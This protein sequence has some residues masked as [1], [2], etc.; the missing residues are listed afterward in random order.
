MCRMKVHSRP[1][2]IS[3]VFFLVMLLFSFHVHSDVFV[4][5]DD[6]ET[7]Y[8]VGPY[9]SY[10]E[11]KKGQ[12]TIG[13]ALERYLKSD[14]SLTENYTEVF[15]Q[16]INNSVF[17]LF[18]SVEPDFSQNDENDWV[19]ELAQPLI[20]NAAL[21]SFSRNN[22]FNTLMEYDLS[23][24]HNS[25]NLIFDINDLVPGKTHFVLRVQ[26]YSLSQ[27]PLTL[28]KSSVLAK[29]HGVS[30]YWLGMYF[31]IMIIMM[32]VNIV[33]SLSIR[34]ILYFY[35][36][37]YI[38]SLIL[39]FLAYSGVGNQFI[40]GYFSEFNNILPF[41]SMILIM[42]STLLF[43]FN[44][45]KFQHFPTLLKSLVNY[46]LLLSLICLIVIF[47]NPFTRLLFIIILF[48][49]Y[50]LIIH[51]MVLFFNYKNLIEM[52]I[53]LISYFVLFV[54]TFLFILPIITLIPVNSSSNI[55]IYFGTLIQVFLLSFVL[56]NQINVER[57]MRYQ[58]LI[59]EN[60]AV[61]NMH[62]IEM[63]GFKRATMDPFTGL[64][65]RA[66]IE[67]FSK[68]FLT[69]KQ[70]N[71]NALAVAL[72]YVSD[73]HQVNRTLGFKS[74]D[75]LIEK[76]ASR[77]NLYAKDLPGCIPLRFSDEQVFF[78]AKLDSASFVVLFQMDDEKQTYVENIVH[79]LAL[80]NRPIDMLDMTLDV[81]AKA[82]MAFSP[83]HSTNIFTLIR[84]AQ[85]A[86]ESNNTSHSS[87]SEYSRIIGQQATR[88]LKLINDLRGAIKADE[89]TFF[90]QPQLDIVSQKIS[91]LETLLRW[92][93]PEYGQVLSDEFIELAEQSGIIYEMT[94]WLIEHTLQDVLW[95]L[96]RG[97]HLNFS[98]NISAKNLSRDGFSE[99][100]KAL[101]N[102]HYLET[103]ILTL[104][105][106]EAS[107]MKNPHY[108]SRVMNELDKLGFH[109]AID[110]F[111]VDSFSLSYLKQAP[112]SEFKI[113]K[114]LVT[115]IDRVRDDRIITKSIIALGHEM[116]SK[117]CADG[118]E[119]ASC[120]QILEQYA[121][122]K[123]QGFH[124]AK[125]LS[126]EDLLIWIDQSQFTT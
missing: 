74:G 109:I 64:P 4:K 37:S 100:L 40:W 47:I 23:D 15:S 125:P 21:Y 33:L 51:L 78:V 71:K 3:S 81:N 61:R 76:L 29:H 102:S 63:E 126:K 26:S 106:T 113:D 103:N 5:L 114:S 58:A 104:E 65:N 94:D 110:N 60:Q 87:V 28:W 54:S 6:N 39:F 19:L 41:L 20:A 32:I 98:I 105:L 57:K 93:H 124:V 84:Y 122:D 25:K 69:V 108:G 50:I 1:W 79:F 14:E 119:S 123:A 112:I 80:L 86:V 72:I 67:S 43:S 92:N 91:S 53:I 46:F 96:E 59:R 95:F 27:Y 34:D 31:G 73:Y 52:A 10:I 90:Y 56:S 121:C 118:V 70:H 17:W 62:Q 89:L 55:S 48:V 99:N 107:L 2:F 24:Q 83:E 97:L 13:D 8:L 44:F 36:A 18:F 66:A 101:L 45:G 120:L 16:G 12:L 49:F 85:A 82:G 115:D 117:V 77:L 7:K 75:L 30:G 116:G 35:A 68:E 9:L 88:K 42:V 38:F 111:G 11:D 22:S